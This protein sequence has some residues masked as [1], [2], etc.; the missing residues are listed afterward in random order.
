MS[1]KFGT[2][3]PGIL[4]IVECSCEAI[5]IQ[6]PRMEHNLSYAHL[7]FVVHQVNYYCRR[8]PMLL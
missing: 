4:I 6:D 3:C 2:P 5:L 1:K 7:E 8:I